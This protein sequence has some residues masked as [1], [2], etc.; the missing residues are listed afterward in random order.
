M[1]QKNKEKQH[2]NTGWEDWAEKKQKSII[3]SGRSFVIQ[4]MTRAEYDELNKIVTPAAP[5]KVMKDAK[6]KEVFIGKE[7][8]FED[9]F[10]DAIYLKQC[11]EVTIKRA[12]VIFKHGLVRPDGNNI[13]GKTDRERWEFVKKGT[14]G[15][16]EKVTMEILRISSLLPGDVDELKKD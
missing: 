13:P 8:Q 12:L 3:V 9:D 11:D 15:V 2:S 5:K 7:I 10:E 6:G 14:A 4:A 16:M 1:T